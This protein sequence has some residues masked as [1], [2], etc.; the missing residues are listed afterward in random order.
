MN[1]ETQAE[2]FKVLYNLEVKYE[3]DETET[4]KTIGEL[5]NKL[6]KELL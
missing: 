6:Q 3:F 4:G 2:L 1:Q 5:I